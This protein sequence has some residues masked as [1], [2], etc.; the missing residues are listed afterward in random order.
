MNVDVV[1]ESVLQ[2]QIV[3]I[4]RRA[5]DRS[6]SSGSEYDAFCEQIEGCLPELFEDA[7]LPTPPTDLAQLFEDSLESPH[8]GRLVATIDRLV[9]LKQS[10]LI[11]VYDLGL[12]RV[13][14]TLIRD[15]MLRLVAGLRLVRFDSSKPA[16]PPIQNQIPTEELPDAEIARIAHL[17]ELRISGDDSRFQS[18]LAEARD[19]FLRRA[20]WRLVASL[21]MRR[22]T[23]DA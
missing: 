3:A 22:A 6:E 1:I 8:T 10:G 16:P 9:E 12:S 18:E 7:Q 11:D 13:R 14:A 15:G 5:N 23:A 17:V 4:N 19:S 21:R 2:D 20:T